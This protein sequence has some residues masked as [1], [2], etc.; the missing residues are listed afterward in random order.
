MLA[1]ARQLQ[2]VPAH[3]IADGHTDTVFALALDPAHSQFVSG[4]LG[5]VRRTVIV[6]CSLHLW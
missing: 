1:Q 2:L 5:A 4:G 3:S 6:P